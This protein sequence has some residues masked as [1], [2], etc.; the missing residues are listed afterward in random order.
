MG[1]ISLEQS[2]NLFWLGR[3]SERVYITLRYLDG[4]IDKLIDSDDK[5]YIEYCHALNIPNIY[6]DSMGFLTSYLFDVNNPDSV[7]S[8]LTRAVDNGLVLRNTISSPSLSYLQMAVN[9]LERGSKT[10]AHALLNQEIID[11]L[12]AFWGSVDEY[13]AS[14][15]DRNLIK[16]GKYLERLDMELR[17]QFPWE[18]IEVT[19]GKLKRRLEGAKLPY[20]VELLK[21]LD[22]YPQQKEIEAKSYEKALELVGRLVTQ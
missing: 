1:F 14:R 7:Y 13:V 18:K 15:S 10:E 11:Y 8:N 21:E 2:N 5:V 16:A 20:D 12:L 22:N 4:L 17:L 19:L 3:Y 9:T 6:P